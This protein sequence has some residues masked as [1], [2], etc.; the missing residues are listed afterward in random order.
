MKRHGVS[1]QRGF[2]AFV[3]SMIIIIG[4]LLSLSGCEI[5][6]QEYLSTLDGSVVFTKRGEDGIND[7]Y[8]IS[9]NGLNKTLVF[10]N[11]DR[12]NSNVIYP[13]WS[14]DGNHIEF[15]AMKDGTWRRWMIGIDGTSPRIF[16][17]HQDN[18][19]DYSFKY[20]RDKQIEIIEG[21]VYYLGKEI[22]KHRS[23]EPKFNMGAYEASMG[24]TGKNVIFV[25]QDDIWISSIDGSR[26][27]ILV[28]GSDPDWKSY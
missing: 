17:G 13:R 15:T 26:Q 4:L 22:L 28:S 2:F 27:S 1:C 25:Y 18:S 24:P 8:M 16:E 20:S 5:H 9:A 23:F 3:I 12:I 7:L 10:E 21:S 11:H 14:S 6:D 19:G